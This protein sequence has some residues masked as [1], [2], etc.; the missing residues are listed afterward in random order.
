MPMG[1]ALPIYRRNAPPWQ[2]VPTWLL[3]WLSPPHCD[4]ESLELIRGTAAAQ[5]LIGVNYERSAPP[6]AKHKFK[7][8]WN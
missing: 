8:T 7:Y 1:V 6:A 3:F 4:T 2:G 5:L